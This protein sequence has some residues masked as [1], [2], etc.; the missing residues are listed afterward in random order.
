MDAYAR[1]RRCAASAEILAGAIRYADRMKKEGREQ[2]HIK[3]PANWLDTQG[4]LP[5]EMAGEVIQFSPNAKRY[6]K[7]PECDQVTIGD[8]TCGYCWRETA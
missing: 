7:C 2:K 4:W 6:F 8:G 1:A 5:D 3:H